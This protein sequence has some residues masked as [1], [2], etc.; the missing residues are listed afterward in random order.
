MPDQ[1]PNSSVYIAIPVQGDTIL[2]L[3]ILYTLL[4]LFLFDTHASRR[5][6]FLDRCEYFLLVCFGF[7]MHPIFVHGYLILQ[8]VYVWEQPWELILVHSRKSNPQIITT[9]YTLFHTLPVV[10]EMFFVTWAYCAHI[11]LFCA[12]YDKLTIY[13]SIIK[14]A[15]GILIL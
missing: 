8:T 9:M 14:L 12:F 7:M 11:T 10:A 15:Y 4:R 6:I 1:R 5:M 3:L 13:S 2:S